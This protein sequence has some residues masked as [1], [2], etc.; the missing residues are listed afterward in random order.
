MD[1]RPM[2][3]T[4][5]S[6]ILAPRLCHKVS[7]A[8]VKY[9]KLSILGHQAHV[10]NKRKLY[11][12]TKTVPQSFLGRCEVLKVINLRTSGPCLQQAQA[13]FWHQDCATKFPWQV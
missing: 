3:A 8:G 7:L 1:I 10:C 11:F 6:S 4:S 13:L 9:K 2:F 12:G 5:A